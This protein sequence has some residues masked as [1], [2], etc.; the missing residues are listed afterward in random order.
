MQ[1]A[2]G[3]LDRS[4]PM[5]ATLVPGGATFRTWA[6]AAR[7][8]HLVVGSA[9]LAAASASG[10]T[11][12]PATRMEPR[13]DGTWACFAAG[14]H[15]GDPYLFWIR[16]P[17]GGSEGFKRDPYA[18][19]LGLEPPFPNCHCLVRGGHT[20]PWRSQGWRPPGFRDLVIYQLHVGV[21]WSVDAEGQDRRRRYGRFLDVAERIPYLAQLGVNAVQ[22]LPIQEYDGGF[23]LGYN[24]L[25]YYSP[26]MAYQVE[27]PADLDR[28]VGIVN[29]LLAAQGAAPLATADIVT[30]PNQLKCLIDLCHLH[31][32]AVIFDLVYN[33][34]GGG[35]DGATGRSIAFYDRQTP[36]GA[37][38]Q[39]DKATLYFGNGEHAGGLVFDYQRD[40]V[41]AFLIENARFFHD[42]Y[43]IDGIR[44]DQVSVATNHP[45][46]DRFARDLASTLRFHRPEAIQLAEYWNWDRARAVDPQGLG[47]DAAL[48]D[49]FRNAARELLREASGGRAATVRMGALADALHPPPGFPDAW[50]AVQCLEDHDIVRWDHER[51]V[52][53][54]PRIPALADPSDPRSWYARSR[55]R[56]A[57][58]LLLTGPGIPMLFMG[59]EFLEDKPWHDDVENWSQFLIWWDGVDGADRHMAD[60]RR[61]VAELIALRRLMPALRGERIRTLLTDDW[62]RVL[63]A[64]RWIEGEGHDAV[65]VASLNEATLHGYRVE[66][67]WPGTWHERFNSDFYDHFPNPA[68][69]GNAGSVC[70][71]AS[72]GTIYPWM[73]QLT[74]PANSVLVFAR[75]P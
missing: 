37:A 48:A 22:L 52:P 20:Y 9:D 15:D 46:G 36:S 34:A 28:H 74:I 45:H 57:T 32:I 13:G 7:D 10:W 50:R 68:V 55:S 33:H 41:R 61:C 6:P 73:V 2:N 11:P 56:V 24:G 8:V 21:F 1:M 53:R 16:G 71:H 67:P 5:G 51:R 44:Y 39:D 63:V 23:S 66:M 27:Q 47:F 29:A 4:M 65:I 30:G 70:S 75:E 40:E 64:H 12:G 43:R 49:G 26:E 18:R 72:Q 58:A 25:D 3:S 54:L 31:G 35:F 17:A 69:S 14:V 59:Q 42:E 38:W 62:N 19:E 60:F